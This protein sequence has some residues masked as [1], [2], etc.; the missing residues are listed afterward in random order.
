MDHESFLVFVWFTRDDLT[1]F[2]DKFVELSA[3]KEGLL[4]EMEAMKRKLWSS[5]EKSEKV[6]YIP[7]HWLWKHVM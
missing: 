7:M 2:K 5:I 1:T 4:G 3:E 6:F